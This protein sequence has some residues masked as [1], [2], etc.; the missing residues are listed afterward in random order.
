MPLHN[1]PEPMNRY[2]R[3]A[4][5]RGRTVRSGTWGRYHAIVGTRAQW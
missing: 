3:F 1:L 4:G 5:V 2:S